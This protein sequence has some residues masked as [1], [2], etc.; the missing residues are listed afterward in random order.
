MLGSG[1]RATTR[2]GIPLPAK[3]G[4]PLPHFLMVAVLATGDSLRAASV[5]TADSA[6]LKLSPRAQ[7][8]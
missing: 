5:L 8:I 7:L 4:S 3:A 6:W 1:G 2:R